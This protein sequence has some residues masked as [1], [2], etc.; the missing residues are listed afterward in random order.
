M[1]DNVVPRFK[2]IRLSDRFRQPNYS[3]R[4]SDEIRKIG[5][6]GIMLITLVELIAFKSFPTI[7]SSTELTRAV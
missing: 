4:K 2:R 7:H 1:L 6:D 5:F 3:K